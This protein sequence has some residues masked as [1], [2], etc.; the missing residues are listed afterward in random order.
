MREI[1]N[2]FAQL[3]A[4]VMILVTLAVSTAVF[5]QW[6]GSDQERSHDRQPVLVS[7]AQ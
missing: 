4:V 5:G 7:S 6:L 2:T 1:F 3:A